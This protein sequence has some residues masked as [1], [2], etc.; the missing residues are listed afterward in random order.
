MSVTTVCQTALN[1]PKN[2]NTPPGA[3]QPYETCDNMVSP[4]SS[5]AR[6]GFRSLALLANTPSLMRAPDAS[7]NGANTSELG[8]LRRIFSASLMKRG[9]GRSCSGHIVSGRIVSL[10]STRRSPRLTPCC[11][12][13][14][15]SERSR[16]SGVL[17]AWT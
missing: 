1:P 2:R 17:R 10:I 5:A 12:V 15:G 3:P 13:G 14:A 11:G 8:M 6:G 16:V 7:L 4:R 9:L